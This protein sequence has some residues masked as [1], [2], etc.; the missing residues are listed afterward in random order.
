MRR[1]QEGEEHRKRGRQEGRM[2]GA[3]SEEQEGRKGLKEQGRKEGAGRSAEGFVWSDE[4][5]LLY[6]SHGWGHTGSAVLRWP[7]HVFNQVGG[8]HRPAEEERKDIG[9]QTRVG[10][11]D[12]QQQ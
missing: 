7:P 4:E 5:V 3:R 12:A 6:Q 9:S 2:V 11:S 8:R 1:R 10:C